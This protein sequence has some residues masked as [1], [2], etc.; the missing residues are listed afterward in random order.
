V[1]SGSEWGNML[2]WDGG[3][4]KVELAKKGKKSCHNVSHYSCRPCYTRW[5]TQGNIEAIFLDEGELITTGVDGF[6]RVSL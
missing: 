6:V 4:I 1:L 3:F 5:Y 2:L